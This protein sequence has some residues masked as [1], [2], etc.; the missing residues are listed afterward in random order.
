MATQNLWFSLAQGEIFGLLGANGAG[1]A[2]TMLL[3]TGE[4]GPLSGFENLLKIT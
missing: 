4:D 1:K 3:L 2:T